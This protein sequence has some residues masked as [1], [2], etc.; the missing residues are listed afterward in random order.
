MEREPVVEVQGLVQQF[1]KRRVLDDI[2]FTLRRGEILG[3]LGPSGSGKTTLV[4]AIAAIGT[5]TDGEV[6]VLGERMPSLG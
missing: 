1:G 4:K 3:L 5:Y 2:S 6:T